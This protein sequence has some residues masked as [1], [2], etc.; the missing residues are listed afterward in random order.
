MRTTDMKR[1]LIAV[2]QEMDAARAVQILDIPKLVRCNSITPAPPPA[3]S[4][5]PRIAHP[6]GPA[7]TVGAQREP[8]AGLRIM[9]DV[10]LGPV[11][12]TGSQCVPFNTSTAT[13]TQAAAAAA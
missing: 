13:T 7:R 9:T 11:A 4:L 12:G 3:L 10:K 8:G 5:S 2:Q 1:Q 6:Q